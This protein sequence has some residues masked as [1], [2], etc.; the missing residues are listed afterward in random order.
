VAAVFRVPVRRVGAGSG[1]RSVITKAIKI[2]VVKVAKKAVDKVVG[3]A[4]PILARK[5][6]EQTWK[7]KGLGE[8]WF[9]VAPGAGSLTLTEGTPPE[10]A[11]SL[12]L[13]HGTFSH[14]NS[15][16]RALTGTDFF[17]RVRPLYD[18]RIYAFNHFS[19]SRTPEENA[20]QLL[21]GLPAGEYMVDAITHSRGGLVLRNLVE[22]SGSSSGA[23][24][25]RFRL[26]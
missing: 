1:R 17:D 8:G 24:A 21:N 22:P 2:A 20:E 16:F 9:H 23:A 14:A 5:W 13:L 19:V 15:A 7:K 4:L 6:E 12:L 26:R 3:I 11:R 18:D 25:G 10:G